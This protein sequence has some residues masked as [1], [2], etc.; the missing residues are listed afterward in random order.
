MVLCVFPRERLW[1]LYRHH[2][3][4]AFDL[5]WIAAREEQMLDEHLLSVGRRGALERVAFV[6]LQLFVRAEQMNLTV[7]NT[8]QFP[9]TQQ[10]LADVLGM[11]LV[12]TNKTLRRLTA[13]KAVRWNSRTFEILDRDALTTLAGYQIN[14]RPPASIHLTP[15]CMGRRE[16]SCRRDCVTRTSAVRVRTPT[17]HP[18]DTPCS[19]R[20]HSFWKPPIRPSL[21]LARTPCTGCAAPSRGTSPRAAIP[22]PDRAGAAR[23]ARARSAAS[24]QART[25]A[26]AAPA[27]RRHA[28]AALFQHQ[29]DHRRGAVG[30]GGGRRAPF[31]DRIAEHVPEFA[32]A[33]QGRHHRPP[34]ADASGRFPGAGMSAA[35]GVGGSRRCCAG[36]VCDF[37]LEW[38]P[39]SRL[40]Y[41]RLA[42]HWVAA[43]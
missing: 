41:H 32:T 9:F 28:V 40:H 19:H 10:H 1:E 20:R 38:T 13:T 30:A 21:G 36:A 15:G 42:A 8:V 14:E 2:P 39:G 34:A 37:T 25:R 12:H 33:R 26:R 31:N 5:T 16:N 11:S 27:E 6:L 3:R 29:G 4:L 24:V 43:C 18:E 23:Q 17:P 35:G 7:D 22:A